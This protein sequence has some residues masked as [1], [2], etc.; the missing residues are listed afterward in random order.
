MS[1]NSSFGKIEV[2]TP[3]SEKWEEMRGTEKVRFCSHCD[4]HVNN[5]SA[6]T[7]K[8]ALQLVGGASGRICV[9]YVKNPQTNQP[10]FR[11]KLYQ[12]S[13]RTGIAA[14]VLGASLTISATNYAQNA[15]LPIEELGDVIK[16]EKQLNK[17]EKKTEGSTS[18]IS[19]T[20]TDANGAVI[21]NVAVTLTNAETKESRSATANADG[22]YEFAS[23]AAGNYT[24]KAD[25]ENGFK[26]S[27]HENINVADG[28]AAK[29][30]VQME[31]GSEFVTMGV[32]ALI[33]Y[34]Q[35]LIRAVSNDDVDEVKNLIARGERVNAKE[36]NYFNITPLFLA[37]ENG[38]AEI[39]QTL[40][41]F[42][43]KINA[44]DDN[45]QTPLMRLDGDAS[46][47]LVN[48]LIKHGAKVNAVDDEGN[49][50]LILAANYAKAE[51]LQILLKNGANADAQNKEGATALMNAAEE[52]NLENVR[53][54]ILAGANV[55]LKNKEGET[56]WDLTSDD[57]IERLLEQHGATVEE[58]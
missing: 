54:L 50:A 15:P 4:L 33:S 45:K 6:M 58:K 36:E 28:E 52:G 8:E 2:K 47:A 35:P 32:V 21:P 34:E 13:R 18:G 31:V 38:N 48:L 11:D 25:G 10:I 19:G 44:K 9:R 42:G 43:A 20:I 51:I 56:A 57:E 53:A 14:G 16:V 3:C 46:P 12:I 23:I 55:S 1:K 37:V 41:D 40:L 5:L 29:R 27:I 39:A 49:T 7:H 26:T 17:S 22:F 24:L 30:D